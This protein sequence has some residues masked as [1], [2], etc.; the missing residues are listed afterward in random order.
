M[1]RRTLLAGTAATAAAAGSGSLLSACGSSSGSGVPSL[2]FLSLAWQEESVKANKALVKQWNQQHPETHVRYVQGSWDDVHDQLLTSFEGGE[3]PDIIHDEGIDLTDFGS[4]GYLADLTKLLPAG[5]R[6]R[7]PQSTWD[8]AAFNGALY[9]VPFLQEPRVLIANRKLL[10]DAGIPL[11]DSD[12]PW[13]WAEFEDI[14]RELSHHGGG[15]AERY[16]TAWPMSSP[17]SVTLNL[18]LTNGGRVLYKDKDSGRTEVRFDSADSAFAE[19]VS[20]QVR[21]DRSAPSSALSLGGGDVLPGFFGGR[22]AMLPLDFSYRQQVQQQAPDHFD[23]VTLPLPVGAGGADGGRAQGVSPQTLSVSKSCAHQE[24]AV[25][26]IDFMTQTPH[27]VQLAQGDW[28]PPTGTAALR[29]PA[30]TT[31]KLGWSTGM[32]IARY[33]TASPALGMRG[34]PEWS[35]KIAT[36][37]LQQY[38]SG[39]I[40]LDSLRG[41]L[42]RDG[43]R[44][45]ERYRS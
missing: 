1:R 15:K 2:D 23:W 38:Y 36:P 27:L 42:V 14:T 35:D 12:H 3:A 17:V 10:V 43:N 44:V 39:A 24:A 29:D 9:G 22:Y 45:F 30:L 21:T 20:R 40:S 11:P 28:M 5:L 19:M 6:A 18:A 26:F 7:I 8:T 34:Y 37:A 32:S 4:G 13:T 25:E 33:L 31:E 41:K 16:G